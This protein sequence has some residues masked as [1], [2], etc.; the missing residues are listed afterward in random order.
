MF[1]LHPQLAKDCF[2]LEE[3][4]EFH[5]LLLNNADY[6]WLI[7]VPHTQYL[8]LH[9]MDI[10]QQML[11][12]YK[13]QQVSFFMEKHF[14]IDKLNVASIGNMVRQMHWHIIGRFENDAVFPAVVWGQKAQSTY[15]EEQVEHIRNAW[16]A[17]TQT[18]KD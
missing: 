9:H 13:V 12:L 2:I 5:L 8:E 7:L 6:P 4:D 1:K 11:W 15:T 18:D 14:Q 3:N 10:D 16:Q 17:H